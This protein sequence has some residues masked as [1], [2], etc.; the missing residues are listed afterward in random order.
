MKKIAVVGVYGKGPDF[1]T[2]QAVKCYVLI[3]WFKKKIGREGVSIINTYKWKY[4]PIKLFINLIY[5]MKTCSNIIIMPAQNGIK[6]FAPLVYFFNKIF[7]RKIY[8]IVIG[9][10]LADML[11]EKKTLLKVLKSFDGIYVE[12]NSLKEKLELLGFENV[13]YMPNCREVNQKDFSTKRFAKPLKLCTYSRVVKEKGILDAI[14]TCRLANEKLGDKIFE[15]DIYGKIADG[16]KNEFEECLSMNRDFVYYKGIKNADESIDVL[17]DYF[18]L[19]FPTFYEGEGFA[20][21]V[22][23]AFVSQTPIIAN[24]WKYNSEIIQNEKNGFIYPYRDLDI[25]SNQLIWLYENENLYMEITNNCKESAQKYS[26]DSV[27]NEFFKR[28][29]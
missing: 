6:V 22:L 15:L 14:E 18:A 17:K 23:D 3:N 10:W 27:L 29:F 24:D 25:A 28:V 1:T 26:I 11:A 19:L 16:F 12:A 4:N 7:H 20:G 8:Y 9:G 2:G 21:T 13:Y 5:S